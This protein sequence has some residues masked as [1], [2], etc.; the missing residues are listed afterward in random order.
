MKRYLDL[1]EAADLTIDGQKLVFYPSHP[2]RRRKNTAWRR[3]TPETH[4]RTLP[5]II[6]YSG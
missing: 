5:V 1:I 4:S 2:D 3:A 6:H